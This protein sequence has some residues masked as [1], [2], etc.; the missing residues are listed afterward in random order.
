M[1]RIGVGIGVAL[2]KL[3]PKLFKV[4]KALKGLKALGAVG[5]VAAYSWMFSWQMAIAIITLLFVHEYGHIWA[6]KKTGMKV[7]G[8][9]FIPFLG[10]AA[11]P[12]E[13]FKSRTQESYVAIMGPIFGLG[14]SLMVLMIHFITGQEMYAGIASWMALINA[15]Q[16]LPINPMDGGRIIKSIFM[17]IKQKIGLI[18]MALGF[19]LGIYLLFALHIWLF[20]ILLMIGILEFSIEYA[21]YKNKKKPN[22]AKYPI[23]YSRWLLNQNRMAPKQMVAYSGLYILI[24]GILLSVMFY[25]QEIPGARE[26]L[27]VLM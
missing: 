16:F 4:L 26:A 17:S 5:S 10:G 21:L 2:V 8:I 9:Y 14:L 20:V 22:K 1:G 3:G 24:L 6:M 23:E 27:N 7:K 13:D 11:V 25:A 18:V 12:D 15:F 19:V